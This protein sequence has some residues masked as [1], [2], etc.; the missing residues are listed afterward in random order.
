MKN[1]EEIAEE[2]LNY[3]YKEGRHEEMYAPEV[4]QSNL[5]FLKGWNSAEEK[6]KQ[7][8]EQLQ[9]ED[10][11]STIYILREVLKRMQRDEK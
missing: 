7:I 4:I 6:L 9:K 1:K 11:S 2:Y 5:D 10:I 8:L 3:L